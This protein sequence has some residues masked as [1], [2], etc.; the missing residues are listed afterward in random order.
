MFDDRLFYFA[1]STKTK[2]K[3]TFLY[4][5]FVKRENY[6]ADFYYETDTV[7]KNVTQ[8]STSR[9]KYFTSSEEVTTG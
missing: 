4:R 6:L 7:G 9:L 3:E 8:L 5:V 2:K 1:S